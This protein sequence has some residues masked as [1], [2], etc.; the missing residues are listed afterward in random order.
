[1]NILER[2]K[3]LPP[4]EEAPREAARF[5]LLDR[6]GRTSVAVPDHL[7][8]NPE[9]CKNSLGRAAVGNSRDLSRILELP[10]RNLDPRDDSMA[11]KWTRLL[12]S[13]D[14]LPC[15]C[16][17]KWGFCI[18]NL[19]PLQGWGLEEASKVAGL[20]GLLA[21]G[22]GKTGLDVL[23]PMVVPNCKVA[24]LLLQPNLKP[25]FLQRDYPQW[26]RHFNVPNLAGGRFFR[27]GVPVLHVI[28]YSELSSAKSTDLLQKIQPDLIIADE[29]FPAGTEVLTD[30]GALPI[31]RVCAGAAEQV[32][33]WNGTGF[34]WRRI[35]RRLV[36]TRKGPLVRVIHTA[37]DF[38]CT[39]N[40]KIWTEERGYVRADCLHNTDTLRVVPQA[41]HTKD[42]Q[43][44]IAVLQ[45]EVLHSGPKEEASVTQQGGCLC[46]VRLGVSGDQ[47]GEEHSTLLYRDVRSGLQQQ[48]ARST[49]AV[50]HGHGAPVGSIGAERTGV[51]LCAHEA[52]A[53][54]LS[55][56]CVWEGRYEK[57][58]EQGVLFATLC[59]RMEYPEVS[60]SEAGVEGPQSSAAHAGAQP[61]EQA[62]GGGE[63]AGYFEGEDLLG[64][65]WEQ[66]A[67]DAP[68]AD[69]SCIGG[70]NGV[71]DCNN[72]CEG[73]IPITS[74]LLQGGCG[75]SGRE[76]G[77][78]GR[79]GIAQEQEVALPRPAQNGSFGGARVVRVEVLELGGD[80]EPVGGIGQ[81]WV[82]NL[83]VEGLHNYVADGVVVSNC[84]N[85]RRKDAARTK[86]F[87]RHFQQHHETR[88]V[89]LSGTLTS[90]SLEDY[91]HLAKIALGEGSPLPL[92]WPT[93]EE[94]AGAIDAERP[95]KLASPI[96]ALKKLCNDGEHVREG[97]RRRLVSTPGV[98]ASEQGS[99]GNSLVLSVRDV[100]LPQSIADALSHVRLTWQRPDGEEL[101]DAMTKA[102][103]CRQL[104]SGFYYRW[105]WP[106]GESKEVIRAWLEA[107]K[108]WHK[109]LRE[110][111]KY[112]REH[113]D[114]PLL[115]TRAAI[116]WHD[117]FV[118]VDENGKRQEYPPHTRHPLTWDSQSWLR[119][120]ATKDTAEPQTEAVWLDD[121]LIHDAIKWAFQ[122][123]GLIWYDH[124]A[125]GEKLASLSDIPF[126]GP[127]TEASEKILQEKGTRTVIVSTKAHGTGKNLQSWHRNLFT[128]M[129][130][131]GKDH[132]QAIGRTHRYGQKAD[133]VTVDYYLHTPELQ[134]AW[135]QAEN[136][137]RYI[138][139]TTG[140]QQKLLY[141]TKTW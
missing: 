30:A 18:D 64:S 72:A 116:R 57:E 81:D 52:P 48:E 40:H 80:R 111:L 44:R 28:A 75:I 46:R 49:P 45:H 134:E 3:A 42:A 74:D 135:K 103:V 133:E 112:S 118:E 66:H 73:S 90:R 114:S 122:E 95:N 26:A 84:H 15:S 132:E 31:E 71:P 50:E 5:S 6:L 76:A 77:G 29:C 119:W 102:A 138:Q 91:A 124:S 9:P 35:K 51:A 20:L 47:E 69:C 23:L 41:V 61:H 39:P 139:A 98:V 96:G 129:S 38:V 85:V 141:A 33:S 120:K 125:F 58:T 54:F 32:V 83:E 21:I 131:S 99:V 14:N 62:G 87:M 88:F 36:R 110:K 101:T 55:V 108:E 12:R 86:R 89:G 104:A 140:V 79:R 94:W 34:E 117:G 92:H 17:S 106:R 105:I 13:D 8:I 109:E 107:R 2:M 137:A 127:G 53:R 59:Q 11:K 67:D 68:V 27:P 16:Y 4:I 115:L 121:Y 10:R 113:L 43:E 78:R 24:L 136:D 37:G 25:Q 63:D 65:R 126:Y 56:P 130:S 7:L 128:H 70:S 123:P 97:F 1:M 60:G 19:L 22:A 100:K 82:Y 93:V